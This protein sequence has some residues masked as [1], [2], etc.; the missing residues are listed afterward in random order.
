MAE[1]TIPQENWDR[2]KIKLRR[3]YIH[4]S[5]EDLAFEAGQEEKLISHLQ[6]RLKR[7]REYVVFTLKKGLLNIDNNRL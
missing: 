4:L 2:L 1:I 6:E 5:E 3:K 7:K